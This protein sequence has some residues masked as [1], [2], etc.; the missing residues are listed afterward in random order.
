[1]PDKFKNIKHYAKL[2]GI[3]VLNDKGK[4]KSV[5]QLS[6]DIWNYEKTHNVRGGLYPFLHIHS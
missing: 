2:Y 3:S 5:G 1:M 4:H 6:V